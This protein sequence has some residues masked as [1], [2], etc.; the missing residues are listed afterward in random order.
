MGFP[1]WSLL[2]RGLVCLV[3]CS[4]FDVLRF[5]VE[6]TDA[7]LQAVAPGDSIGRE[8]PHAAI[9]QIG[10]RK[11]RVSHLRAWECS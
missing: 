11:P 9:H 7:C 1:K 3:L 2:V 6:Y 4:G 5:G 8:S 10:G